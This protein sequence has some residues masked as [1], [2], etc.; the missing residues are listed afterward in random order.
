[1]AEALTLAL[2]MDCGIMVT[3]ES[4]E[5][6]WFAREMLELPRFEQGRVLAAVTPMSTTPSGRR[7]TSRQLCVVWSPSPWQ[8]SES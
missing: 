1:M 5:N 6:D 4:I 2:L 8:W 3:G 7:G